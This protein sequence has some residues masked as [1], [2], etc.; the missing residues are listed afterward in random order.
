MAGGERS[1]FARDFV[2]LD[3]GANGSVVQE[4]KCRDLGRG[5]VDQRLAVSTVL[6]SLSSAISKCA[7]NRGCLR[8]DRGRQNRPHTSSSSPADFPRLQHQ[9]IQALRALIFA[10]EARSRCGSDTA[11][12]NYD[13][14]VGRKLWCSVV[15][16]EELRRLTMPEGGRRVGGRKIGSSRRLIIYDSHG[17]IAILAK[18]E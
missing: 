2:G 15:T 6:T 16:Q 5:V 1:P 7:T 12:H 11:T 13:I 17:T 9:D 4:L 10:K 3:V 18:R 14:C 8:G